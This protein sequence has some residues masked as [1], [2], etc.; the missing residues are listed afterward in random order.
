VTAGFRNAAA[1][2]VRVVKAGGGG[3]DDCAL[4]F[5]WRT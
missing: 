5:I 4:V 3:S 2:L 1:E